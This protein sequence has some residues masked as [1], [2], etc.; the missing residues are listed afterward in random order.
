MTRFWLRFLSVC[1]FLTGGFLA[2]LSRMTDD[3]MLAIVAVVCL[4]VTL[5]TSVIAGRCPHCGWFNRYGIWN[6]YCSHC[7]GS[8]DD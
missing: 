8:M 3:E 1:S 7:G 5:I 4:V 2:V 6:N